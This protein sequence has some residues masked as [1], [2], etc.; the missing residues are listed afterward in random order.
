MKKEL[1]INRIFLVGDYY[2]DVIPSATEKD[3]SELWLHKKDS[4]DVLFMFGVNMSGDIEQL[5]DSNADEYINMF[6]AEF[7]FEERNEL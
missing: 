5:I 2:I 7:E 3:V 4:S 1:Q 6:K